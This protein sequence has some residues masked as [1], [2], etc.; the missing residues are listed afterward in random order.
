MIKVNR[1]EFPWEAGL[2]V[3]ALLDNLKDAGEFLSIINS[4][5]TVT[6][7]RRAIPRQ[8]FA[9]TLIKDGDELL[10]MSHL[11]GG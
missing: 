2:T 8:E 5:T 7:N 6:V 1:R 3:Q 11:V 4:S 9:S 10:L